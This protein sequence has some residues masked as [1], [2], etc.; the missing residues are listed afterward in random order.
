VAAPSAAAS[1]TD[2]P[3]TASFGEALNHSVEQAGA[4]RMV[5]K[6]ESATPGID[7]PVTPES[8][9]SF[10]DFL[11]IINPLQHIPIV[12]DYYR[13]VTG[14][15]IKPELKLAGAAATGGIFG[16]FA[17]LADIIF[18]G[19]TGKSVSKTI[20]SAF[21]DEPSDK[22][23][24]AAAPEEKEQAPVQLASATTPA[25]TPLAADTPNDD[26]LAVF[27]TSSASAHASYAQA[28]L[29][30]YL[31]DVSVSEKI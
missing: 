11:D 19:E 13:D 24:A 8:E 31:N 3:Q 5:R 1:S 14:D 30:N 4:R 6:G 28:N 10:Y 17:G 12:S 29:L 26:V 18:E 16:F 23:L 21:S 15:T 7:K 25:T 27:G 9:L 2:A 20:A 22:Q